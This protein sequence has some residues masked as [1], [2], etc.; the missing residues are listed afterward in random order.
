MGKR[1]LKFIPNTLALVAWGQKPTT[2]HLSN[3]INGRTEGNILNLQA[4]LSADEQVFKRTGQTERVLLKY[5]IPGTFI[6]HK[7]GTLQ[8]IRIIILGLAMLFPWRWPVL[9]Q[10]LRIQLAPMHLR[11]GKGLAGTLNANG[12]LDDFQ[13][14]TGIHHTLDQ[15]EVA[16]GQGL[17]RP[18]PDYEILHSHFGCPLEFDQLLQLVTQRHQMFRPNILRPEQLLR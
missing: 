8:N 2:R 14:R 18:H 7:A 11:T 13:S 5:Y 17:T 1:A 4:L 3:L 15:A 16:S 6:R 10:L 9:H 12:S